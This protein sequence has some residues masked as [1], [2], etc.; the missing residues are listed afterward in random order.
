MMVINQTNNNQN[1]QILHDF[2]KN[3]NNINNKTDNNNKQKD[4]HSASSDEYSRDKTRLLT[5][6]DDTSR[7]KNQKNIN[8]FGKNRIPIINQTL[9]GN[10]NINTTPG[11]TQQPVTTTAAAV[12]AVTAVAPDNIAA[13]QQQQQYTY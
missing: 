5:S 3:E 10:N 9:T 11:N 4:V 6:V 13:T 7:R 1:A 12:A 8:A 2:G